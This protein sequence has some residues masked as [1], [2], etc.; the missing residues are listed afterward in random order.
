MYVRLIRKFSAILN[1]LD[2]SHVSVGDVMCLPD[3]NA[4]MLVEE[5]WA[6]KM[7]D[8]PCTHPDEEE[9]PLF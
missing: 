7:S 3:R 4:L 6:E 5:G 1:G 8:R 2:L 9:R